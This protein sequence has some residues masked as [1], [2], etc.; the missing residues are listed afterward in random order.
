MFE[1]LTYLIA[2]SD[3]YKT[4]T[5]TKPLNICLIKLKQETWKKKSSLQAV[6]HERV[7]YRLI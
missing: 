6:G 3:T 4:T 5:N 1:V 7:S 2:N